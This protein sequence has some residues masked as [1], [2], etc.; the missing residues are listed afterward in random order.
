MNFSRRALLLSTALFIGSGVMVRAEIISGQLPWRP[1]AGSP[2]EPILPGPWVFF[3]ADEG[4]AIEAFAD[5]IIPADSET[6]GGKEAGSAIFI[7]RQLAGPYGRQEGLYVRPP[8]LKG[9][10]QQGPQDEAGPAQQYRTGLA[11][12]DRHCRAAYGGK[13]FAEL[14]DADK[15]ATLA[16]LESSTVKLDGADGKA[17][18]EMALKDV[19]QG[20][21]ADPI[22][23][24]NRDMVAWRMIGYPGARYDYRDWV[25]RHNERFPLPPVSITGRSDWTSRN[26]ESS[27]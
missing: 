16:G 6:P 15:D 8:F 3:T 17:F 1:G 12:L 4:A 5:R 9:L 26:A 21:F 25:G 20:F 11:A 14:A 7:D 2:P 19:Q 13:A 24:G 27:K 22:Y 10:K 18:F 23:G